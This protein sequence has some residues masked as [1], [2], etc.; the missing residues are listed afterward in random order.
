MKC[1]T[2]CI[3]YIFSLLCTVAHAQSFEE[4]FN[5]AN[6][7]HYQ[8]QFVQA[9]ALYD[10]ALLI[11]PDSPQT[12]FNKGV[13]FAYCNNHHA[14]IEAYLQAISHNKNY[15]KAYTHLID[16]LMTCKKYDQT[17]SWVKKLIELNPH[18]RKLLG[19]IAQKAIDHDDLAAASAAYAHLVSLSPDDA[20]LLY[21]YAYILSRTNDNQKAVEYY[22][23]AIEKGSTTGS[24]K[25]GLAKALLS[26]GDWGQGWHYFEWRLGDRKNYQR[27]FGYLNLK[28]Q[29]VKGKRVLI[30]AEWGLGDMIH[31]MR[32]AKILKQ[33]GATVIL[34]AF[35]PLLQLFKRCD[36]LDGVI[37]Q[38]DSIP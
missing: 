1:A 19:T 36:F 34:Q 9:I 2:N 11:Q 15:T 29:D 21:N 12:H 10:Q 20:A 22:K 14:A 24:P 6:S 5:Q 30:R 37:G 23:K 38:H 26:T 8:K 13:S 18:D 32:Y 27:A 25:L 35:D 16:A 28:P 4:I 31:F 7:L 17:T 3:P 33:A